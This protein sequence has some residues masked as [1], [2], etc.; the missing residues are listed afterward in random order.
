MGTHRRRPPPMTSRGS[1]G[2]LAAR[3]SSPAVHAWSRRATT[4]AEDGR[5]GGQRSLGPATD[6][7]SDGL[8]GS[9]AS[10]AILESA[11]V[12]SPPSATGHVRVSWDARPCRASI[13][14]QSRGSGGLVPLVCGGDVAAHVGRSVRAGKLARAERGGGADWTFTTGVVPGPSLRTG[15]GVFG[16]G[17]AGIAP[18]DP[19][20]RA[21]VPGVEVP[22]A[23]IDAEGGVAFFSLSPAPRGRRRRLLLL[24]RQGSGRLRRV[25]RG[26]Q[27]KRHGSETARPATWRD[28]SSACP[29][30]PLPP[31]PRCLALSVWGCVRGQGAIYAGEDSSVISVN[32]TQT[33]LW[34][35]A[36]TYGGERDSTG[37]RPDYPP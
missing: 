6:W 32:E 36:A 20:P 18:G 26:N 10:A 11:A 31:L 22:M 27:W 12:P 28:G 2:P 37:C 15:A 29:R 25:A 30:P 8:I 9:R 4:A 16:G 7:L 1:S 5:G 35:N 14:E 23:P 33:V 13:E 19:C 17:L 34:H 21:F 3:G 24:A